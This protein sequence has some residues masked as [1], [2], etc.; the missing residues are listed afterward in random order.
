MAGSGFK[1]INRVLDVVLA[2]FFRGVFDSLKLHT[3]VLFLLTSSTIRI[4]SLFCFA[5]NYALFSITIYLEDNIGPHLSSLLESLISGN[6]FFEL[7]FL[8]FWVV[9]L[10][11][12]SFCACSHSYK[13]IADV[14]FLLRFD[15][16]KTTGESFHVEYAE[17]LAR[18]R[19]ILPYFIVVI[20]IRTI[21]Y[22]GGMFS[23]FYISW[24]VSLSM[25]QFK[26][27]KYGK[28]LDEQFEQMEQQ[29]LYFLGFGAPVTLISFA[30]EDF[31]YQG[32]FLLFFPILL[33]VAIASDIEHRKTKS[34]FPIFH[35]K[36]QLDMLQGHLS[37][38]QEMFVKWR[39]KK[40]RR[41]GRRRNIHAKNS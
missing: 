15:F 9:P 16:R 27:H 39:T 11:T 3:S 6:I 13:S 19:A 37:T 40:N 14:A 32:Y 41:R 5:L 29:S 20:F 31:I 25:F 12:I 17:Q 8:L 35:P 21:P 18:T 26:W 28:S 10:Y 23:F 7:A 38:V 2:S 22:V 4:R 36:E 30:N 33:L 1:K 34:H 24:L